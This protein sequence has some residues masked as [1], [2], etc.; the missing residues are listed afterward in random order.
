MQQFTNARW[1]SK[2][3]FKSQ[4]PPYAGDVS[5]LVAI[6]LQTNMVSHTW[7][8]DFVSLSLLLFFLKIYTDS[9]SICK[10]DA[11]NLGSSC[12]TYSPFYY[13]RLNYFFILI[14]QRITVYSV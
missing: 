4:T 5:S 13:P 8:D 2:P 14:M 7:L 6:S 3:G 9:L 10:G 12:L 1:Y 11:D